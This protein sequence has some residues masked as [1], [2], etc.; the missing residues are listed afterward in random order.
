MTMRYEHLLMNPRAELARLAGFIG[1]PADQL[2]LS[3]AAE[4]ANPKRAGAAVY[5]DRD[6][7]A[8]L[9]DACAAGTQAFDLLESRDA[10]SSTSVG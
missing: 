8:E 9:R 4:F 10:A 2:W 5:L 1:V 6:T 7:L 3:R